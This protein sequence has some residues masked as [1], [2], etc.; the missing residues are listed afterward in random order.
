MKSQSRKEMKY[1]TLKS[2]LEHIASI[3]CGR[4]IVVL[5]PQGLHEWVVDRVLVQALI[6]HDVVLAGHDTAAAVPLTIKAGVDV[7]LAS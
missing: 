6:V 5:V 1:R 2:P 3:A 4:W 7:L